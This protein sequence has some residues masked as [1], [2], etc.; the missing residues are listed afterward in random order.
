MKK[1]KIVTIDDKE[2]HIS[3]LTIEQIIKIAERGDGEAGL[4]SLIK[5]KEIPVAAIFSGLNEEVKS[6]VEMCCEFTFEDLKKLA[7]S[8]IKLLFQAF[9]EVNEDFLS[10]LREAGILAALERIKDQMVRDFSSLLVGS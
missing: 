4:S 1:I 9:R 7:P 10:V 6:I 3:E 2:Y 5:G 8:E